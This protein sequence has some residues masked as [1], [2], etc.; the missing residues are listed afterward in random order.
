[1]CPV[2]ILLRKTVVFFSML[3]LIK[4]GLAVRFGSIF[5]LN[6][7]CA[8]SPS[9]CSCS[10]AHPMCFDYPGASRDFDIAI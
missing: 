5:L 4:S 8:Y 10:C 3:P 1:M 2:V 9:L 7:F 6:A